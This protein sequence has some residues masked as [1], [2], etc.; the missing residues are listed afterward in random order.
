M[1]Q[2]FLPDLRKAKGRILQMSSVTSRF[3]LPFSAPSSA[4][5]AALDCYADALRTELNPF[6]VKITTVLPAS[7]KTMGGGKV[8]KLVDSVRAAM[9][10]E[11]RGLYGAHFDAFA[12]TFN[13][14]QSEGLPASD[15]ARMIVDVAELNPA[16]AHV[17]IGERAEHLLQLDKE[18]NDDELDAAQREMLGLSAGS[19]SLI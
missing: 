10:T 3:S 16:P 14:G 8:A 2:A 19:A 6:G 15:A 11:Q 5:K 4:A 18:K 1:I 13:D 17:P 7:M 12:D 9:T